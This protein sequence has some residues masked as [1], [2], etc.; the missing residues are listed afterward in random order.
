MGIYCT[1]EHERVPY[2][3]TETNRPLVLRLSNGCVFRIDKVSIIH[4]K[5]LLQQLREQGKVEVKFCVR[6]D[7]ELPGT[8]TTEQ[9]ELVFFPMYRNGEEIAHGTIVE[10]ADSAVNGNLVI[11]NEE[12]VSYSSNHHALGYKEVQNPVINYA[13]EFVEGKLKPNL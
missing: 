9:W 5:T 8:A 3:H 6:D 12:V 13:K 1:A 10:Y 11:E 7:E 2:S 4:H